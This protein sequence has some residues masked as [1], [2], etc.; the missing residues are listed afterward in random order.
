MA[1]TITAR[2]NRWGN[3]KKRNETKNKKKKKRKGFTHR[4]ARILPSATA[5]VFHPFPP[6][7]AVEGAWLVAGR[8]DSLVISIFLLII[9]FF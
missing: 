2:S 7:S 5:I 8:R 4:Q 1:A 3:K 9:L 6:L